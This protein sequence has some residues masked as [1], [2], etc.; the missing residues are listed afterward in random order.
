MGSIR[1]FRGTVAPNAD[2]V[3]G[4][5]PYKR[6][7]IYDDDEI[8]AEE[9]A[10]ALQRLGFVT[11]TRSGRA[12]FLPLVAA[13]APDLLLLDLHMPE[14]DGVEALRALRDYEAKQNLAVILASAS[15]DVM[16]SSAVSIARAYGIN[17]LGALAK[18]IRL[19]DVTALIAGSRA[20]DK[21]SQN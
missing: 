6:V 11:E 20:V 9:C 7:L 2:A 5:S 14:F 16:L 4:G 3:P 8:Y 21:T 18:P 15:G 10:E 13:F 1:Q 19:A 12:G 17:L